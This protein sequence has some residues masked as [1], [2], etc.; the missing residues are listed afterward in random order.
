[1]LCVSHS[2]FPVAALDANTGKVLWL[3]QSIQ[4]PLRELGENSSGKQ[5]WGPAGASVWNTPTVDAKRGLIYA[6]TGNNFGRIAAA[7]SD[8]I[9]ALR[10]TDGKM[11]WHHQEFQGDAFRARCQATTGAA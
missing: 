10:M 5:R 2:T 9:L 1:M 3:T 11:I 4:E 6:G 7:T 8:S